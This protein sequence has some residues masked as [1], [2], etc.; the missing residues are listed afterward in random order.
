MPLFGRFVQ[1]NHFVGGDVTDPA[2]SFFLRSFSEKNVE[3]LIAWSGV[4]EAELLRS[5]ATVT[6]IADE[7]SPRG[8]KQ[9]SDVDGVFAALRVD[10]APHKVIVTGISLTVLPGVLSPQLSH[11]PGALISKW[12]I[13]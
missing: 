2:N 5:L 1:A 3:F 8:R 11:A 4:F 7:P 13:P 10:Q 6:Q 9:R 12:K